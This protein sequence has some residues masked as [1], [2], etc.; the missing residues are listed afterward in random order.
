MAGMPKIDFPVSCTGLQVQAFFNQGVGQLHGFWYFEAERSFREVAR[1]DP[2]CAMAYWG[3]T[4]ANAYNEKRAQVFL[5][6]AIEL[7]A[8]ADKREQMW[9]DA[10]AG[11][12]KEGKDGKPDF[13]Q[14]RKDLIRGLEAIIEAHPEDLEAKAF[15]V[16]AVWDASA[17]FTLYDRGAAKVPITSAM[18]IDAFARQVLAKNPMHPIHHYVIHLWDSEFARRAVPSAARSGQSSPGIAHMWHMAGHTFSKVH[19]LQDL[20]WQQEASARVDHAYMARDGIFP[21]QIHNYGHNNNW[22]VGTYG[23]VGRVHDA[24]AL[25][26]NLVEIPQHPVWNSLSKPPAKGVAFATADE[27]RDNSAIQG[28][29]RLYEIGAKFE[30]WD[31]LLALAATPHLPPTDDLADQG[32]RWRALGLAYFAKGKRAE[33]GKAIAELERVLL[34]QKEQKPEEGDGD[35][36]NDKKAEPGKKTEAALAELRVVKA[37]VEGAKVE[38]GV[39]FKEL[40][41]DRQA[42]LLF[43]LGERDKALA[44]VKE[45]VKGAK[46][47]V[48]PLAVEADLL[49]RADRAAEAQEAFK[50]LRDISATIDL[51]VPVF[52]RL[53]PIAASLKLPGDWRLPYREEADVAGT[54]PPLASLGPK[55]W[56]PPSAPD[57]VLPDGKGKRIALAQYRGKPVIVIFYLGYGCVHCLEQLNLFAPAAQKFKSAGISLLAVSTDSVGGLKQTT[58]LPFPLLSDERLEVFKRYRA[59]DGFENIP[60]H[61]TFLIDGAGLVRWHDISYEPFK[62][63]DFLVTEGKRLL[64]FA[65][66]A[67]GV[68][69][70]RIAP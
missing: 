5:K 25:A 4:Q 37:L 11:Y 49:W 69:G 63:V 29:Q 66:R 6:K 44:L 60:L 43:E 40:A 26:K 30:L 1:L 22:L 38:P 61:G 70:R 13:E 59:F 17:N 41:K 46:N 65:S 2:K 3:M 7:R 62:E 35:N 20:A 36:K 53:A 52:R 12:Y 31:E 39:A 10:L 55:F 9:L 51:D 28:R 42:A 8:G 34:R 56:T 67:G 21:D 23:Q 47:D 64:Q 18:T 32:R 50:V 24:V 58:G 45:A 14:R 48:G 68:S 16:L 57:F 54:R 19:R 15:L 33:G 27:K